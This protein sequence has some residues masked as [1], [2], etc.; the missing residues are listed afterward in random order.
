[1]S[2]QTQP[3]AVEQAAEAI[4]D[5][6]R[7]GDCGPG[8]RL[9]E[10]VLT[11][12]L[13][14]SRGSLR[15]AFSRL[16]AEGLVEMQPY[17]GTMVSKLSANDLRSLYAVRE[18][19]EGLAARLVAERFEDPNVQ[20]MVMREMEFMRTPLDRMVRSRYFDE[21]SRFHGSLISLSGNQHLI[22][23]TS[24]FATQLYRYAM[25]ALIDDS[26]IEASQAEHLAILEAIE[27]GNAADAELLTRGHLRSSGDVVQ[28]LLRDRLG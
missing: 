9:V 10:S 24:R 14:V 18:V 13:G 20:E 4:R 3:T 27:A 16:A 15:E 17:R 19:L 28:R 25:R 2:T 21:N 5:S 23:S 26:S 1:M 12:E 6:I 8:H 11:V 7:R 22:E